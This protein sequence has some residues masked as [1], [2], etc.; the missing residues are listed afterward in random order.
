MKASE[1]KKRIK[2]IKPEKEMSFI[3]ILQSKHKSL[4]E[5]L[6]WGC[7][8]EEVLYDIAVNLY[9]KTGWIAVE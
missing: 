4:I 1:L 2:G 8:D 7:S 9:R 3:E 6:E 5:E